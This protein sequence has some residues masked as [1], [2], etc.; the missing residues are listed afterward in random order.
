VA[1]ITALALLF[2]IGAWAILT[3]VLDLVAAVRLRREIEGEWLLGLS[4]LVS[5]LFGAYVIL[6]PGPA[7]RRWSG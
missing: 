6:F 3:G 2:L 4:G 5:V 1:E 7:R